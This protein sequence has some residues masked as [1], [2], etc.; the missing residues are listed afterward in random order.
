MEK[1]KHFVHGMRNQLG[2]ISLSTPVSII[3]GSLIIA[4][5]LLLN[6]HLDRTK[7]QPQ[8]AVDQVAQGGTADITK[9]N[10]ANEPYIGDP[11]A[12]VTIAY[13]FDYQCPFCKRLQDT[14]MTKIVPQY[15]AT[16][17]VKIV[18]KDFQFLGEDSQIAGMVERA[19][20][21]VAPNR[22]YDWHDAMFSKQDGENKDWGNRADILALTKEVLGADAETKI[23]KLIT[24]KATEYQKVMDAD[25]AEAGTLGISGTPAVVIG[26][27][28]ISGAQS[29]EYFTTAIDQLLS[30]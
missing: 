26:N 11:N 7:G 13:W 1:I 12:P 2:S 17:K 30:K 20:W 6:G 27:Y 22:F 23:E 29:P 8:A 15:V 9:V 16:G 24:T 19:V 10:I 5:S 3:I 14:V 18:F 4:A 21:E 25:K 28:L